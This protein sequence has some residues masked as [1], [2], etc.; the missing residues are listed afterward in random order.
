MNSSPDAHVTDWDS[1]SRE[2]DAAMNELQEPDR[3]A[4]LL[5]FF[6]GL[7]YRAVGAALNMSDNTAQKRVSRALDKLR[8][9]LLGRGITLSVA[10]L[11]V[12]LA[13]NA[14]T[15]PPVGLTAQ[16]VADVA[17]GSGAALTVSSAGTLGKSSAKILTSKIA[18]GCGLFLLALAFVAWRS[19]RESANLASLPPGLV[20]WW[21]ADGSTAD[22]AGGN[23]GA[24]EGNVTFAA[25]KFGQAF[26][27]DG[28]D[29]TRVRVASASS[30][31]L[32]NALTIEF[33]FR[34]DEDS[35]MGS[36][37][38]KRTED[39]N[40][41]ATGNLVNYGFSMGRIHADHQY[42]ICQFFNDPEVRGGYHARKG[43]VSLLEN[44]FPRAKLPISS[45]NFVSKDNLFEQSAFFP[46]ASRDLSVLRGRWHHLAGAF[47]QID[48]N[49]V[50]ITSYF[51]GEKRNQIVLAGRLAN[52]V[53]DAPLSIGGFPTS[54]F[55]GCLDEVRIFNRELSAREV[56]AIFR[57]AP[58]PTK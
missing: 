22:R 19:T 54:P 51:D 8:G 25:G 28:S 45:P 33:W 26:R 11:G 20:S 18:W 6:Q 57:L 13:R 9:L 23:H 48:A 5:R 12:L 43:G 32:T 14:V 15:A 3:N 53:N 40:A 39:T 24:I 34:P 38:V 4:I 36:L 52:T 42:G 16:I 56:R 27:F 58:V 1:L 49:H 2:L 30:L 55:K 47:R 10:A 21:T 44:L 17:A 50:R 35:A 29:G 37:L 31:T 46:T 41:T 7:D